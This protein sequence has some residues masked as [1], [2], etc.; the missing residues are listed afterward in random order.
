MRAI[1]I[2]YATYQTAPRRALFVLLAGSAVAL[3]AANVVFLGFS[4]RAGAANARANARA[5]GLSLRIAEWEAR[6]SKQD[7]VTLVEAAARGF[8][9]PAS[10]S[11]ATKRALGSAVHFGNEL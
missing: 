3:V 6:V 10:L 8:G 5:E 4:V 1:S 2:P 9:T 7:T 11:Y